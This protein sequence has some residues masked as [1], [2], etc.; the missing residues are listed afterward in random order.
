MVFNSSQNN[1]NS[2]NTQAESFE[3]LR[4]S[5]NVSEGGYDYQ[6]AL[7]PSNGKDFVFPTAV[8]SMVSHYDQNELKYLNH[9]TM[10]SKEPEL[11]G[12]GTHRRAAKV[13]FRQQE[14]DSDSDDVLV[15]ESWFKKARKRVK[16]TANKASKT[17]R[18]TA[19]KINR[20]TK[21]LQK[22]IGKSV[23]DK[24]GLL[25]KAIGKTLDVALPAASEALGAAAGTYFAGNP[26][27]GAVVGKKLG[28]VGRKVLKNKTK[29]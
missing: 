23:T 12:N 19:E 6:P 14:Q 20:D 18:K 9:D 25:H 17:T 10:R 24:N 4:N 27:L 3:V 22:K 29:G 7:R 5:Y 28:S 2:T 8:H 21:P 15:G 26:E 1:F 13:V 16:K 11:S